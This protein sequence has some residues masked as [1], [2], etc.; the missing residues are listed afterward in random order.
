M[1]IN[2]IIYV[3]HG[4]PI[5]SQ[6]TIFDSATSCSHSVEWASS[7]QYIVSQKYKAFINANINR[8]ISKVVSL[9]KLNDKQLKSKMLDATIYT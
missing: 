8:F 7:A 9:L 3:Q 6:E 2:P 4:L 1:T 5:D